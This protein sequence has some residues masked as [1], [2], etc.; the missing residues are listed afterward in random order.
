MSQIT[1]LENF[2]MVGLCS[3]LSPWPLHK[4][5][6]VVEAFDLNGIEASAWPDQAA[7]IIEH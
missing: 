6:L 5:V 4:Y 2:E 3:K 1:D 7:D